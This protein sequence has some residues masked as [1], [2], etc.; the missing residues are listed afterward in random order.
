[1]ET[2]CNVLVTGG[3]GFIGSHTILELINAGYQV[4]AVD[5]FS[6]SIAGIFLFLINFDLVQIFR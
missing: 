6:N 2:N 4:T 1:M 5:N 3:S